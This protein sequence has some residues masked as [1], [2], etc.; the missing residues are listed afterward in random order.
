MYTLKYLFY[1][2]F[3][4][5]LVVISLS[6]ILTLIVA[7][8]MSKI[9]KVIIIKNYINS[10]EEQFWSGIDLTQFY[11]AN[12]ENLNHP[13][14]MIFKAIFEE[15]Q[16][17]ENIRRLANAKA[18]IKERMLN[19][20]HKQKVIIMQ[21]CETYMDALSTFIHS[22]PF[23]GLLGTTLGLID[24]FYNLDLENGL[25]LTNAG[26]GIGGSLICIV[27]AMLVVIIA[28]PLFWFFNMKIQ[29]ISDRIDGYIIDVI[30]IFGRSLDSIAVNGIQAQPADA[31]AQ[32]AQPQ[33]IKKARPEPEPVSSGSDSSFLDDI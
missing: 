22:A 33:P 4:I 20:A 17:S 19:V 32:L 26:I 29:D 23:L 12:K 11:E 24:V 10:F 2:S 16:A 28:M 9:K 6:F 15:W 7:M 14:G 8:G 5:K 1:S 30:N 31:G 3:Y 13:L 21:T 27:F 25:T 18:D